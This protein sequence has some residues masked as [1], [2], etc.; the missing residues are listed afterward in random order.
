[1]NVISAVECSIGKL[2]D[3]NEDNFYYNG[4]Y[5][6]EN[7]TEF[8]DGQNISIDNNLQIYAVC[9]GMGGEEFGEEASLIAVTSL[10]KYHKKL[11]DMKYHSLNKYIDMYFAEVNSQ[12]CELRKERGNCRIGTTIA[13]LILEGTNIHIINIGDS[14]IYKFKGSKL[15]QLTEDHTPAERAYQMGVIK[16]EQIKTHPHRNKLTQYLGLAPEE[17]QL[18]PFRMQLKAKN[19]ERFLVC[20]DGVTDMLS[21]EEI[22]KILKMSK[23]PSAAAK[24][25][26]DR[27]KVNGGR[28]NITAIV[29]DVKKTNGFSL[30]RK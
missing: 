7:E 13:L 21:D 29:V 27:A 26:I 12:I 1:M 23:T 24:I 3:N 4:V 19:N 25:L 11:N 28:D 17:L 14:R 18:N 20:S 15:E 9:D 2:R 16:K 22:S 6:T 30:F 8:S 10:L 5:L